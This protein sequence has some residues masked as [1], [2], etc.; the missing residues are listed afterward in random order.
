M[1]KCNGVFGAQQML[2]G[3]V[4]INNDVDQTQAYGKKAMHL[5]LD[6]NSPASP[7]HYT[8]WYDYVSGYNRGLV[9]SVNDALASDGMM[10]EEDFKTIYDMH[11]SP[12][13][14]HDQ[15]SGVSNQIEDEIDGML[16]TIASSVGDTSEYNHSLADVS[17]DL[18]NNPNSEAFKLLVNKLVT[19]TFR[20]EKSNLG[21]QQQLE[22]SSTQIHQLN[23][24][25]EMVK[26][27]SLTD[28]LTNIA[29][30]KHFDEAL[31]E[32][33]INANKDNFES[34]VLLGDIDFFKQFND[35]YGHQ[36]GDQVLRLVA[37]EMSSNVKGRDLAARYG[38]EEFAILLPDTN[39]SSAVIVANTIRE[40]IKAKELI[41][42]STGQKLG[43]VTISFGVARYHPG[44]TAEEIVRRADI[45]LYAAKDAGRDQVKCETDPGI[46]F[47]K[48]SAA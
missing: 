17:N 23:K 34:C 20:M 38:G 45:C 35:T 3:T 14:I 16:T 46:E 30:R 33:L 22:E 36:T 4:S 2:E 29:N 37:Q 40:A 12:N 9:E 7:K 13:Q 32:M 28:K 6:R 42:K 15:V 25:L 10:S 1:I 26:S 19:A 43:A 31:D 8:L 5:L 27:E 24:N 44:D 21:L 18:Q 48:E 47:G 39:M 11:Y 41:K